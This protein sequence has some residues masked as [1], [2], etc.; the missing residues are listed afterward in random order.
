MPRPSSNGSGPISASKFV[1]GNGIERGRKSACHGFTSASTISVMKRTF[2]I[3]LM[4]LLA[5]RAAWCAETNHNF[6]RWEKEI[7]AY[8]QSDR[9]NPPPK[10]SVLFI[11]SSTVRLWKTLAQDFP[12]HRVINRGFGGSQ[13]IDSAHFAERII[14]PYEPKAI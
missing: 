7:A 4:V 1:C 6:A 9:T 11:G 8:E 14:F 13:I 2:L 12:D 10:G 3:S 5:A